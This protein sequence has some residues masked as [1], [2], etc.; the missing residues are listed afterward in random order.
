MKNLL[1]LM[2]SIVLLIAG[3]TKRSYPIV[4]IC[5]G[6]E[7]SQ[8]TRG[9]GA[10]ENETK[11]I[12]KTIRF[13]EQQRVIKNNNHFTELNIG[14]GKI[15]ESPT[16]SKKTWVAT[17]DGFPPFYEEES[18]KKVIN[19]PQAKTESARVTVQV[20]EKSLKVNSL[21]KYEAVGQMK[22]F[23]QYILDIDRIS[24]AY[25]ETTTESSDHPKYTTGL[26]IK[27]QGTCKPVENNLQQR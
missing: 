20:D 3:C 21:K 22:T 26:L 8:V 25:T 4:L 1:L 16:V 13:T 14:E 24:G 10:G 11:N 23:Q 2:L 6:I 27:A 15:T 17:V 19:T 9:M 7:T 5:E 12:K 18:L